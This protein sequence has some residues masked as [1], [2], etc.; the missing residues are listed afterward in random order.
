MKNTL[1]SAKGY[2]VFFELH[3][4]ALGSLGRDPKE[5]ARFLFGLG[6]DVMAEV[7]QHKKV[8]RRVG[9]LDEFMSIVE[10]CLTTTEMWKDYTNIFISK[11]LKVPLKIV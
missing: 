7:D 3:P 8:A 9:S 4:T 2:Q 1:D 11:G 10:E 5:F 6:F